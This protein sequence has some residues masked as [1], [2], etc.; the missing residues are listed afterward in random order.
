MV[1]AGNHEV[2]HPCQAEVSPFVAYQVR[3]RMPY[4]RSDRL[5]RRNM[6][7]A[8]RTGLS[9]F[10]TLSP[11]VATD[12]ASLQYQWLEQELDRVDRSVTPWIVVIMH[13]PWYN[14]NTAH[15][16]HEPQHDMKK[17][18]EE[19]L[20]THHVDLVLAGHVHAYER[21]HPVYK[22]QVRP[23]GI[24]YVVVG[25]GGNREGLADRYIS[26]S[27]AWS[28]YR[29]ANYGFAVLHV[30]NSTHALMEWY[31]DQP[32]GEATVH[33][34]TWLTSTQF[35]MQQQSAEDSA[36]QWMDELEQVE[37]SD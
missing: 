11:Y 1:A 26:P 35:R 25:D 16:G 32:D 37:L 5:Q 8:F 15:Q 3:F 14:S 6:Y 21:S 7:Y 10:I 12:T 22:E 29:K 24:T 28:A 9:H 20:F 13:G 18:M 36:P 31:K 34:G 27:P 2:E 33:D 30:E 23:D 4:D 17:A 19:L